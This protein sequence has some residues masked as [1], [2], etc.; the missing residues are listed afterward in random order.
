MLL[1]LCNGAALRYGSRFLLHAA[2]VSAGLLALAALALAV[3][4]GRKAV[5]TGKGIRIRRCRMLR[6]RS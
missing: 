1:P 2:L 3:R 5:W 4:Q 6:H